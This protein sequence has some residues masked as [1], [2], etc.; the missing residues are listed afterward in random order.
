MFFDVQQQN[1]EYKNI[2][3]GYTEQLMDVRSKNQY[4]YVNKV[5]EYTKYNINILT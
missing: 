5:F 1:Y 2:F 3:F 4:G